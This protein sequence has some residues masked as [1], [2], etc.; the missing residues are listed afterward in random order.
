M[1]PSR[2]EELINTMIYMKEQMKKWL[3]EHPDCTPEEAWEAGYWQ[4]CDNW[5]KQKK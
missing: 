4:C 5:C 2:G 1:R 3:S